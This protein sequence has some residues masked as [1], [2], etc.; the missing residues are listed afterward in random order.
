MVLSGSRNFSMF[1][2]DSSL[3]CGSQWLSQVLSGSC[4][5]SLLLNVSQVFLLVLIGS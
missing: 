2:S 1:F 3:F 4:R 5:F